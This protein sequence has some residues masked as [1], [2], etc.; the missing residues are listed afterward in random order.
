[1]GQVIISMKFQ[2][3]SNAKVINFSHLKKLWFLNQNIDRLP[4]SV[5][6]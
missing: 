2:S 4:K 1:M 3:K 5:M 6:I